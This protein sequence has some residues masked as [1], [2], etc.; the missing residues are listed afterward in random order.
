[1]QGTIGVLKFTDGPYDVT[2][3]SATKAA[4]A[5]PAHRVKD[6]DALKEFFRSINVTLDAD[7]LKT[8]DREN[9]ISIHNLTPADDIL[10][11]C[12]PT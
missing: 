12:G 7:Q 3:Y 8:L 4:G 9:A 2:F 1:M 11:R 10:K 6:L 5:V